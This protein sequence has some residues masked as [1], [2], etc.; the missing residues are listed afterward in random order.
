MAPFLTKP[1][2]TVNH[3]N[4]SQAKKAASGVPDAAVANALA[5]G[6]EGEIHAGADHAEVIMGP[7]HKIP[8]E[9]TDPADMW[10]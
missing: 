6:L 1:A 9:I 2:L 4:L 3:L 10:R 5:N 7:V 8:A